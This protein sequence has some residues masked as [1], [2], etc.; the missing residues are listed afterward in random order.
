MAYAIG[1]DLGTTNSAVAVVTPA[2]KPKIIKSAEGDATTPSVVLFQDFGPTDEPLVGVLAKHQAP[3]TPDDTIQSVKRHMG[4]PAWVFDSPAGHTFSAEEISAIILKKLKA[5]AEQALGEPVDDVVITVPAYFDDARR[6]ATRQAGEIA[7]FNVL[8][9]LNEPTAAALAYGMDKEPNGRILVYDLGGGTFDVSILNVNRGQ[10]T[11]LATDG[12]RNLGGTDFDNEL[13]WFI[14]KEAVKRDPTEML[15]DT[16]LLADIRNKAEF[17]KKALTS[18]KKTNVQFVYEG[19]NCKVTISRNQFAAI[20]SK[21]VRR[22]REIVEDVLIEAKLGWNHIDHILL[23]GGSTRMPI[24]KEMIESLSGKRVELEVNPDEVV[25]LGAAIQ[26][27]ICRQ[28]KQEASIEPTNSGIINGAQ[29]SISDVTSQAL[30][31]LMFDESINGMKNTV[32]IPRNTKVPSHRTVRAQTLFDKQEYI[33]IQ[34]T[35]GDDEDPNFVT[36]IGEGVVKIPPCPKGT[37]IEI[38]YHYDI[39]QTI[40]VEVFDGRTLAR[41][42]EFMINRTANLNSG[43][44]EKAKTKLSAISVQ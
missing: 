21:L 38:A 16:A 15:S 44:V 31:V 28:N 41:V 10:F 37:P 29:I 42:G 14:A 13:I 27:E 39:D 40:F 32:V 25:A 20:T 23:V 43:E 22:T 7:G 30:S 3:I 24:I 5:D 6:V 1:I 34:V 8:R 33:K 9:V 11:V 36:V 2:G 35:Q 17:A 19:Q 18:V 4:E 26:A 12:D